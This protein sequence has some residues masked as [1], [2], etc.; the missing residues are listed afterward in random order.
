MNATLRFALCFAVIGLV[1]CS[2]APAVHTTS[3]AAA[4]RSCS[5]R[6]TQI[7]AQNVGAITDHRYGDA[8][9]AAER[10][11]RVSL[12]CAQTDEPAQRFG[13]RWRGAN[14]LVVAAELAHQGSDDARAHRLLHEGYAIMRQ[15]RPPHHVSSITSTLIAEKLDTARRDMQGQW[16]YW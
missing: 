6:A 13:D 1:A 9:I 16:A 11:A 3:T 15:L 8:S 7:V 2:Q 4:A 5:D 14:A 10:A 12:N